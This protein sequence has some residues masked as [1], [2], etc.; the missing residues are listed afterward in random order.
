MK[1]IVLIIFYLSI[2]LSSAN[3]QDSLKVIDALYNDFS[4]PDASA[5][6]LLGI[7]P[8]K[9]TRPSSTKE[10]ASALVNAANKGKEISPGISIEWAPLMTFD[11]R[12]VKNDGK[13]RTYQDFKHYKETFFQRNLQL[14]FASVQDSVGSKVALGI[15]C[16]VFDKS[17]PKYHDE[18]ANKV[19]D[20]TT[21]LL[22]PLYVYQKLVNKFALHK[23]TMIERMGIPIETNIEFYV[24]GPCLVKAFN[25]SVILK[26]DSIK[27]IFIDKLK[28]AKGDPKEK[29]IDTLVNEYLQLYKDYRASTNKD[30]I[31]LLKILKEEQENYKK[32]HW[33]DG[34]LKFG[35]GQVWNSKDNTWKKLQSQKITAYG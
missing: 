35:V 12:F 8:S 19:I 33:N 18:Y 29:I 7:N 32:E 16:V 24:N 2:Y 20:Q 25:D 9:I 28:L 31:G 21:Q 26:K 1:K 14:S 4:I 23:D 34:M 6:S 22:T 30:K 3:A 15:S 5:F 17:D 11:K 10:L 27:Q 13:D